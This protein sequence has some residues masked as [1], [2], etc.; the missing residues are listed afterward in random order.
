M[1]AFAASSSSP[2]ANYD[3]DARLENQNWQS[4]PGA[5]GSNAHMPSPPKATMS[6][7]SDQNPAKFMSGV[8]AEAAAATSS[9]SASS[10]PNRNAMQNKSVSPPKLHNAGE[11][12]TAN[13]FGDDSMKNPISNQERERVMRFL[14]EDSVLRSQVLD[15]THSTM[16]SPDATGFD[17]R[18]EKDGTLTTRPTSSAAGSKPGTPGGVRRSKQK[19]K[20]LPSTSNPYGFYNPAGDTSFYYGHKTRWKDND[21]LREGQ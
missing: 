18:T 15:T 16:Y 3:P 10:S 21:T 2:D 11:F 7:Y 12:N 17:V 5:V 6:Q 1:E 19:A 14:E 20:G 8:N 9:S 4:F 13:Q